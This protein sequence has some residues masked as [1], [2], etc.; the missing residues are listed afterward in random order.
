MAFLENVG[1]T[2]LGGGIAA[3]SG[4]VVQWLY[5][6]WERKNAIK[7]IQG[8]LKPEFE[9]LYQ[10][11]IDERKTAEKA[12]HSS[13]NDFERLNGHEIK[14]SE[15]LTKVGGGRLRSLAWDAIISSGNLIKLDNNEI[16][17]IQSAHHDVMEY[18]KNMNRLQKDAESQMEKGFNEN[19]P[20]TI[21]YPDMGILEDYLE[22]YLRTV[23]DAI[24]GFKELDEL[25]W[26]DHDKIK[27]A[28]NGRW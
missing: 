7:K 1:Y 16:E 18:N 6:R 12:K 13:E 2:I 3:I 23:N 17:I 21:L 22:D 26:F 5:S 14:I 8:L 4:L 27:S 11:L 25:P 9:E 20:N 10:I 28:K 24:D 15:Y 19:M